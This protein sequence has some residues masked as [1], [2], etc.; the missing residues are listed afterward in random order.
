MKQIWDKKKTKKNN[1]RSPVSVIP[2]ENGD[3]ALG[4]NLRI[5]RCLFTE[6]ISEDDFNE[7]ELKDHKDP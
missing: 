2:V 6:P 7:H 1:N 4:C 5:N 3:H